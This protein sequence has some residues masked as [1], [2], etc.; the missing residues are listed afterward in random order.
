M[1]DHPAARGDGVDHEIAVADRT[2]AGEHDQVRCRAL[3]ERTQQR[4]DRVLRRTLPLGHAAVRGDDGSEREAV[5]VVDVSVPKRLPGFD[6][7]VAGGQN[8]DPRLRKHFDVDATDGGERPDAAGCDEVACRNHA[9]ARVNVGAALADV[10]PGRRGREDIDRAGVRL[11]RL[12]HHHDRVRAGGQRG[13]GGDFGARAAGDDLRR[14]GPGEDAIQLAEADGGV[15]RGTRGVGRDDRV[16]VHRRSGERRDVD[17]RSD[18]SGGDT[19]GRSHRGARVRCARSAARW[20]RAGVALRRG[21]S[22]T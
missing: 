22:S 16:A 21:K 20:R 15:A 3:V 13:A 6:D 19:S 1:K 4:L 7:L 17:R 10:L 8:R 14:Y 9:I 2:A 12:F 11:R 18:I 5:D